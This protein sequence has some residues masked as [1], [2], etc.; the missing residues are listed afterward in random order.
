MAD[1]TQRSRFE[2]DLTFF[3]H[4]SARFADFCK[5]KSFL[6]AHVMHAG[7]NSKVK[8]GT[9]LELTSTLSGRTDSG[10]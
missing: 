8:T 10:L 4:V 9:D 3:A 7:T 5:M 6:R 2:Y 1:K